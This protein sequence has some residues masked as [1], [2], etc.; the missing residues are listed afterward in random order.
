VYKI[1]LHT[2]IGPSKDKSVTTL[3]LTSEQGY[4]LML[5]LTFLSSIIPSIYSIVVRT[6]PGITGSWAWLQLTVVPPLVLCPKECKDII[7][8]VVEG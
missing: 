1:L 5:T 6:G 4:R 7:L 2:D 8:F 3:T